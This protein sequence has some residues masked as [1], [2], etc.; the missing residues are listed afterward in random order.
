MS[1]S[2]VKADATDLSQGR[3]RNQPAPEARRAYRSD[4]PKALGVVF[5]DRY[6]A[7]GAPAS[8]AMVAP[9]LVSFSSKSS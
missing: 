3:V 5:E 7:T 1:T 8:K 6:P 4:R 9:R 2:R